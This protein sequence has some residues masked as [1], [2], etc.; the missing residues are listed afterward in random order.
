M[1]TFDRRQRDRKQSYAEVLTGN[2]ICGRNNPIVE[3]N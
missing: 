1:V 3:E 2:I